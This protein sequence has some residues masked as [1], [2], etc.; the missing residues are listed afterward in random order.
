MEIDV[1]FRTLLS[2]SFGVPSK[3][4]LPPNSPYRAPSEGDA[5][6]LEPSIHLS[7]SPVYEPPS[8]FLAG[9]LWREMPSP[10]PSFTHPPGSP[11][12]EPPFQVSLTELPQRE[13]LHIWSP[14]SPSLKI[15]SKWTPP[16]VSQRT[17]T[18]RDARFQSFLLH[19]L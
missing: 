17:P 3:G 9:P 5:P 8:R 7:T 10:E 1:I 6:F 12:K 16:Q 2:I 18:D 15:P 11:V 19:F 4:A 14:L 13:M